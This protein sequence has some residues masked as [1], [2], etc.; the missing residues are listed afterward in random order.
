M[1]FGEFLPRFQP[2]IFV[3]ACFLFANVLRLSCEE[4]TPTQE[5]MSI[6]STLSDDATTY[7]PGDETTLKYTSEAKSKPHTV[8]TETYD[9]T[10]QT[11]YPEHYDYC[12]SLVP[13]NHLSGDCLDCNTTTSCIYGQSYDTTCVPKFGID[14]TGEQVIKKTY[15]CRY[16]YQTQPW[17]QIC[18]PANN[19]TVNACPKQMVQVNCSVLDDVICLGK[20]RFYK[21]KECNW[22][23]GYKWSTAFILSITL[24]GFGADRFY[25]GYWE[26]GLGKLFSFG[27][28]GIWTLIDILLIGVGYIPP[29]DGSVYV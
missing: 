8:S 19:C 10:K 24:G 9:P 26:S 29:E 22:T 18:T 12:P 6:F 2:L 14:C 3:F 23:S 7:L 16:C 25:L 27:G 1:D 20:R 21:K 11:A 17:E 5:D 28:I 15:I 4:T 13:C